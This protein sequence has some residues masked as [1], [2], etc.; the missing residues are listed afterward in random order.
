MKLT[1]RQLRALKGASFETD[2]PLAA[3]P[4]PVWLQRFKLCQGKRLAL[5]STVLE[6]K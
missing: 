6:D 1:P 3:H 4:N 5:G 2:F